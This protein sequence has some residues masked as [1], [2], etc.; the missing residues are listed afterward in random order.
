MEANLETYETF[1][2]LLLGGVQMEARQGILHTSTAACSLYIEIRFYIV[3]R[4]S[5]LD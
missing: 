2:G 4:K 5:A 3:V 1:P